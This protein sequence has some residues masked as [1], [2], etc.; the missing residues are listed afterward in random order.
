MREK[1]M[2][3]LTIGKRALTRIQDIGLAECHRGL[4]EWT[5]GTGQFSPESQPLAERGVDRCSASRDG[6]HVLDCDR[7]CRRGGAIDG[8]RGPSGSPR[9]ASWCRVNRWYV[10][11][12]VDRPRNGPC[13]LT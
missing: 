13:S 4:V 9:P 3:S 2:P 5:G 8:S 10:E 7:Q 11:V 1:S 6:H 12:P